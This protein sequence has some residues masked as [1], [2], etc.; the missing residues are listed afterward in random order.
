VDLGNTAILPGLVNAHTHLELAPVERATVPIDAPE[1]QIAWLQRVISQRRATDPEQLASTTR[2][3]LA[4]ALAAG[5]T[6]A[7]EISVAGATWP[8]VTRAPLRSTVFAEILGLGRDRAM[9]TSTAAWTWLASIGHRGEAAPADPAALAR[10]GLSPHA[11]YSTAGWLYERAASS[12]LPLTTHLAELP[13]EAALLGHRRGPL[14]EF[15]EAIGAWD[16]TWEPVGPRPADYA[17]R[18]PLRRA[19]WI[20]AHATHYDPS[21]FWQLRPEAAPP[22]FRTAV[23]FCPRTHARFHGAEPHPFRAMLE[24][25]VVVALGTDSLASAPSLSVLDEARF[26][27]QSQPDLPGRLLLTMSTL[28]G[29]W[30]LRREDVTGSLTPGKSADLALVPLP[31]RDDPPDPHALVLESTLPVRA[32]VF[33]GRLVAGRLAQDEPER[34]L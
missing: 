14:R 12:G 31:D 33:Q 10:P 25:G 4:A 34:T 19:D 28:F 6:L 20:I 2:S 23:A 18:G 13:E 29:A 3:N 32:T 17:R 21:E 27:H 22:G 5:T 8:E 15:L 24:R 9:Q 30:A 7:A 11:P 1:P 26:L 16:E